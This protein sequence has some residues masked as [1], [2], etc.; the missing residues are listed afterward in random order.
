MKAVLH[1]ITTR[2][3]QF[4]ALFI[5]SS[6]T[7][8][9]ATD[10]QVTIINAISGVPLSAQTVNALEI[11]EQGLVKRGRGNTDNNGQIRFKLPGVGAERRYVLRS[12]PYGKTVT[13]AELP[14]SDTY[15]FKVGQLQVE[16]RHG[17]TQQPLA[18]HDVWIKSQQADGSLKTQLKIV[19][20]ANGLI[21]ADPAGIA[22]GASFILS[23]PSPV[24]GSTKYSPALTAGSHTVR[25]GNAPLQVHLFNAISGQA[26]AAQSIAVYT[27]NN[28][29]LQWLRNSKTDAQGQTILDLDGLGRGSRYVLR[30][31]P[32]GVLVYSDR[33]DTPGEFDFA[34]GSVPVTLRDGTLNQTLAQHKI[35]AYKKSPDGDLQATRSGMTDANGIVHF[36]LPGLGQG[37]T[38]VLRTTNP[39]GQGKHYY[40]DAALTQTGPVA[41][42]IIQ[43]QPYRL[44]RT[45]P[46][47]SLRAPQANNR[48]SHKGFRAYIVASDDR[49]VDRVSLT[50]DDPK[51][52]Q[53]TVPAQFDAFNDIWH[54]DITQALISAQRT[55]TL[56]VRAQDA[57]LNAATEQVQIDVIRDN[58]APQLIINSHQSGDTVPG[59]GFVVSGSVSDNTGVTEL[60]AD[61]TTQNS[62][63]STHTSINIAADGRWALPVLAHS[64]TPDTVVK[65][66][67]QSLDNAG[68]S[69]RQTLSFPV[70]GLDLP[71][72]RLLN[73]ITFGAT[74][75]RITEL[76]QT[77]IDDFLS[78]Q[79]DPQSIDDT[80]L[81]SLLT[82]TPVATLVDLKS[83]QLLR[84]VYSKRQLNEILT[85]FWDNH[86]NTYFRG[87]DYIASEQAENQAFR[88]EAL[89][90]FRKL[91]DISAK[92]PAM[93]YYL[94]G[95]RNKKRRPNENY[96]RE[97]LELHTMGVN[98]GYTQTDVEEVARAFTGWSVKEGAFY[99]NALQH[100]VESKTLLGISLPAN[101]GI[102]DGE[103]V[104][105]ILAEHP[106][107]ARLICTKLI[108]LLISDQTP[109]ALLEH[110]ASVFLDHSDAPDQIAQVVQSLLL[111]PEFEDR[112][113]FSAKIKTPL[114]FVAALARQLNL[115][116][117]PHLL[118]KTL[119]GLGMPLFSNHIPTGYPE[120][121]GAWINSNQ[122]WQ[123]IILV[124]QLAFQR[125]STKR[126]HL[127]P[128]SLV[129]QH[130]VATPQGIIGYL[131]DL[132]FN[133]L[134]TPTEWRLATDILT[135]NGLRAFDLN[136]PSAEQRLRELI[137]TL[138]SLPHY[139]YQ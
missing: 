31:R 94:N 76:Q 122:L 85:V 126:L 38:Y 117:P 90:Q 22:S 52:G 134:L 110:C 20:D 50:V 2:L 27:L 12:K 84:A 86:F 10:V 21:R 137:A 93:L 11:T 119:D 3:H 123:R 7:A 80:A 107:T 44:D 53:H 103:T 111:A 34:V 54:A 135:A 88:A 73:R 43:G 91:L 133:D 104:L 61:I 9:Q 105:D 82:E 17:V 99:F 79:L 89:G 24:D 81:E 45:P 29:E 98:G 68:N 30:A 6:A 127:N 72:R 57:L 75:Q 14:N 106:S 83:M 124:N 18:H 32:Y 71:S 51:H 37:D 15:L 101:G 33:I 102:N 35:I 47:V 55:M 120:R 121:G 23:V 69:T 130:A 41:F 115:Q 62:P 60:S 116:G 129:Q 59:A 25:I 78:A 138:L 114:E 112:Q 108:R 5:L 46:Q 8:A 77:G 131:L 66:K 67:L 40:H 48:V 65:I 39:F 139:Q 64:L 70:W 42:T 128:V 74:P 56:T 97:L 49:A 58:I 13:T 63:Q 87:S 26:L 16:L 19:S 95:V 132:C 109:N 136:H 1:R 100:D 36:D 96:S 113:Y 125:P 118:A 28:D 4:I 92:S